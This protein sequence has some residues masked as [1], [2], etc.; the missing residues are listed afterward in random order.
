MFPSK[1]KLE[2][3]N[4]NYIK[5]FLYNIQIYMNI[6]HIFYITISS[7]I[8]HSLN[9]FLS[10]FF[11][12][13][14]FKN[15]LELIKNITS[16]LENINIIYVKIF[17]S[18]CLN[19]KLLYDDEKN[20][21]LKYTDN[22]PYNS[23]DINYDII[24]KLESE[25]NIIL[26]IDEVLN[27]GIVSVVFK[28]VYE[29]KK[30][31]IKI[32]KINIKNKIN[33]AFVE[34]ETLINIMSIIPY[35]RKLNLK[36]CLLD[37]KE[38]LLEQTNF[39]KEVNNIKIFNERNMN[40]LEYIIPECYADITSIY[41]NVIVM[42]NIKGLTYNDVK[43][44]DIEK[45]DIFGKLL[46][47]FGLISILYTSAVHC[48]IH[49]GNLFF[50]I[51]ENVKDKPKYQLGLIDFG[52]VSFPNRDNQ[53]FYYTFFKNI[54]IDKDFSKLE[55]VLTCILC[56]KDKF[57]NLDT[58]KKRLLKE[59]IERNIIETDNK[60]DLDFFLKLSY[61]INVYGFTFTKEFNQICLSLQV[62]ENLLKNLLL[63]IR[64]TQDE[65]IETFNNINK[66]ITIE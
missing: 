39:I 56:E 14:V 11:N 4:L 17:Q 52:I 3:F 15:R 20:Y 1:E 22:V 64:K 6:L 25:Y 58:I 9:N 27:S 48:D 18:L 59:T 62:V 54:Q 51:N 36:K 33:E 66:L 16:K 21:L 7:Y 19:D 8:N 40:N 28:G 29:N 32:L 23:N 12:N 24:D 49:P 47:K 41:N 26:D 31:V 55:D 63:D 57:K 60:Y 50:Y 43:D 34:M 42:E 13:Y 5:F 35:I 37:N 30:V 38:L 10:K 45:K 61:T 44:L 46:M 65:I 2:N 53:N